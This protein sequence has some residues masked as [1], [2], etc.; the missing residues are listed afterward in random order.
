VS[1]QTDN[2][3][4]DQDILYVDLDPHI[5]LQSARAFVTDSN[6]LSSGCPKLPVPADSSAV[7]LLDLTHDQSPDFRIEVTHD[8]EGY[9]GKCKYF[10]YNIS[11]T[12][13]KEGHAV[14]KSESTHPIVSIFSYGDTINTSH[15]W[16]EQG[17]ILLIDGCSAPYN[18]DFQEGYI[19]LKADNAHGYMHI[20]P[21]PN[22][23]IR[24]MDYGYNASINGTIICGQQ[25]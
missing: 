14:A 7:Y 16:I 22:Y 2:A 25:E 15:T 12:G 20:T 13:L 21:I 10:T 24:I 8:Y 19:G 4:P 18:V 23:G 1:C 11:I 6:A 3:K 5:D 17:D 9:C